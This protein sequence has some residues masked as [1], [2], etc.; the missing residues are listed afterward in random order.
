MAHRDFGW[1]LSA[2]ERRSLLATTLVSLADILNG[3]AGDQV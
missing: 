2:S 3:W 1:F